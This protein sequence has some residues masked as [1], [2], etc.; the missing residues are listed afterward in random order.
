MS[1]CNLQKPDSLRFGG[2]CL[3]LGDTVGTLVNVGCVRGLSF[4]SKVE[5]TELEFDNCESITKFAKGDRGSFTLSLA[6]VDFTTL[7]KTDDGLVNLA[8][9]AGTPVPVVDENIV[10]LTGQAVEFENKN[11]DGTIV[12]SVA[13]TNVGGTIPYVEGTDYELIVKDNGYTALVM[14][15]GAGIT[16]GQTLEVDYTYT[17]NASK[18][19]TFNA[20]GQKIGKYGR[21]IHTNN[22]G[23]EFRIDIDNI[24]N[25]T[26]IEMP[27]VSNN[28][29]DV[30]V[31]EMELEGTIVEMVDE[32]SIT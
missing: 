32:Q 11:G 16:T 10:A 13:V 30:M 5:N 15:D 21:I 31:V 12:A 9:V 2:A 14:I 23:L 26:A 28:A 19:L 17:P 7:S 22:A 4:V 20:T 1:E 29:D 24:T 6:E 3:F 25:I 8:L 18:V 27:F